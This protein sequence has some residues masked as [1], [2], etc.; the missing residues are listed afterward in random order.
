MTIQESALLNAGLQAGLMDQEML[1]RC[2]VQA[3]RER[4][5]LLEVVTREG[6]F[7]LSSLYR[8]Y[9]ELRAMPFLD[10]ASMDPDTDSMTRLSAALVQRRRF[11]PAKG[12]DGGHY[13]VVA[14]PDDHVATDGASRTLGPDFRIA[15][16]DPMTLA[17][18]L[19][20]VLDG[21]GVGPAGEQTDYVAL[22][23]EIMKEAYLR[24]ASDIHFEPDDRG[25][26]VRLRV[27]GRLQEYLRVSTGAERDGLTT[28]IKVLA[29]MDI[30]EQRI[31]Q[32]G[33]FAYEIAEW[34]IPETDIR[35]AVMPTR[36]GERL[37]LRLLGQQNEALTLEA[38]GMPAVI[39]S[40]FREAIHRPHGIVL[41][42][43]PTG[44]GKST[45]LY[46]ALRE[47]DTHRANVMTVEDPVE[48]VIPAISQVQ[49]TQK[50]GFAEAVRA[51]LRHDPDVMLI[52]EIR[53][54]DTAD[55]A[56]KA[57]LTGHLVFSTL[58]TNDAAG[59]VTRLIDIGCE[60]YLIAATLIGVIAQRL[61]RRLCPQC[62]SPVAAEEGD[63]GVTQQW[64]AGGCAHCLGTGYRS[65][66]G[67]FESLW[68]D[69]DLS[70]LIAQGGGETVLRENATHYRSLREDALE[71]LRAGDTSAD[72]LHRL[73][74]VGAL[75]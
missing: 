22:L 43:G 55:A 58:H 65:R 2:R 38:L 15:L 35:V 75:A 61:A 49:V 27:D 33:A 26:K 36:F 68:V 32:D 47:L 64:H 21:D 54:R 6:R 37:T 50:V 69:D 10:A 1:S 71:K 52:G 66:I 5:R 59:A 14:D 8:A 42:T 18:L 7:P 12:L 28:R 20:D 40:E 39:L 53:D 48:Q 29:G 11:L 9:A 41:V 25:L 13:L 72:E 16:T 30:S 19:S 63:E 67:V 51:F 34:D 60:P 46:A 31:A 17:R 62:K 24:R 23:D 70:A 56:L 57:A 45:T 73:G 4:L 74:L 3:R 44:S